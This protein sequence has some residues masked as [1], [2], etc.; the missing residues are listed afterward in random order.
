MDSID[1]IRQ[2]VVLLTYKVY[3]FLAWEISNFFILVI[4]ISDTIFNKRLPNTYGCNTRIHV[5][6]II[7]IIYTNIM[8]VVVPHEWFRTDSFYH[9]K[10]WVFKHWKSLQTKIALHHNIN[11]AKND[12]Q[13]NSCNN[14]S[15]YLFSFIVLYY[16]NGGAK[17][18]VSTL[19]KF[20][21]SGKLLTRLTYA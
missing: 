6:L 16:S 5:L 19:L 2:K 3:L 12:I 13:K 18:I 21:R 15:C 4:R 14:S 9:L 7:S 10:Q 20:L 11:L 17:T 8:L 1:K